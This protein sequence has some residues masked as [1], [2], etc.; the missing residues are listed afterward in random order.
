MTQ[1]LLPHSDTAAATA[2]SDHR[3][4]LDA[5]ASAWGDLYNTCLDRDARVLDTLDQRLAR[6]W[7]TCIALTDQLVAPG[8]S[9]PENESRILEQLRDAC[10]TLIAAADTGTDTPPS[11]SFVNDIHRRISA[12]HPHDNDHDETVAA[13]LAATPQTAH[14]E[15]EAARVLAAVHHL[16]IHGHNT[17]RA[18]TAA[19]SHQLV[20]AGL[21]PLTVRPAD[22]DNFTTSMFAADG[23]DL[24]PL[25]ACI[26]ASQR[27]SF[28][29]AVATVARK[30]EPATTVGSVIRHTSERYDAA[31]RL[32][33]ETFH[34]ARRHLADIADDLADMFASS[35]PD[36]N[37]FSDYASTKAAERREWHRRQTIEAAR[38]YG[39]FACTD[40]YNSWNRLGI[41]T[42]NGRTEILVTQHGVGETFSGVIA[43]GV[44]IYRKH[45]GR[46]VDYSVVSDHPFQINFRD[47]IAATQ[48]RFAAWLAGGTRKA[49]DIWHDTE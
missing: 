32:A 9:P 45:A 25:A 20:R 47:S 24:T 7:S 15:V 34:Q 31:T 23:G 49:L 33:S 48:D 14:P 18:A 13:L 46:T 40:N 26:T 44:V 16:N 30:T 38:H 39:Y 22:L 28:L 17:W 29:K 12:T 42:D 2:D 43:G 35:G 5:I 4:E 6:E 36:D 21:F 11:V 37:V 10:T 1:T 27:R 41:V 8:H 3:S 19:A